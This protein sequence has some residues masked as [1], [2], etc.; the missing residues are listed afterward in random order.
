MTTT[1]TA[2]PRYGDFSNMAKHYHKLAPSYAMSVLRC[3]KS[4]VCD[5]QESFCVADVGAGTGT[6]A[7]QLSD[8]GFT[9]YAVEPNDA[10]REQG[11]S[12]LRAEHGFRWLAGSA[13]M[14]LLTDASVDWICMGTAFHCVDPQR[15]L[16]EF[17]RVLRP[18]G[19][20]T[21]IWNLCDD[22][23]RHSIEERIEE[24][25]P[26]L[27]RAYRCALR[28]MDNVEGIL[29]KSGQFGDCLQIE[30]TIFEQQTRGQTMEGWNCNHDIVSQVS[31][32]R[33]QEILAVI[34]DMLPSE[35]FTR[36]FRTRSWTVRKLSRN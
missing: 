1:T 19:F 18:G 13:E 24:I 22:N 16:S 33:W 36:R 31:P 28:V 34:E 4:H 5:G 12:W 14:T 23:L 27:E 9:G 32:A 26:G 2:A 35:S 25:E 10:M 29:L 11:Q 21:A 17:D 6:L 30:S 3:L 20:F 15:T 8:L 7:L